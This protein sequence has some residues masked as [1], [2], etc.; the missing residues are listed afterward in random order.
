MQ[1]V[2]QLTTNPRPVEKDVSWRFSCCWRWLA[3]R[4]ITCRH[5]VT[6][7]P[8]SPGTWRL[9]RRSWALVLRNNGRLTTDRLGTLARHCTD[10][11]SPETMRFPRGIPQST[12]RARYRRYTQHPFSSVTVPATLD[13]ETSFSAGNTHFR[14]AGRASNERPGGTES[15]IAPIFLGPKPCV[16]L[17]KCAHHLNSVLGGAS[18]R[19][20]TPGFSTRLQS[21]TRKARKTKTHSACLSITVQKVQ[22]MHNS[23]RPKRTGGV[24]P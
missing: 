1:N 14:A 2:L 5:K 15:L 24:Y 19:Q 8:R 6:R 10:A 21:K 16:F 12:P 4:P 7:R 9:R 20:K 11:H 23:P 22:N 17:E 18:Y 13:S 3:K